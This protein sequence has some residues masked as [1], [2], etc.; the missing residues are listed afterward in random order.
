MALK[1]MSCPCHLQIFNSSLR[2]WRDLPMRLSEFGACHRDEPSGA[3][4]GLLRT[5]G[6]V[7]DD[8]HVL[9]MPQQIESEV[10]RFVGLLSS[11]YSD[12]GF[13]E[14]DVALSL[15]PDKRAGSDEDRDQAEAQLLAAARSTG[16]E[17][18]SAGGRRGILWSEAGICLDRS[19]RQIMAVWHH[20][21]RL[22]AT[23]TAWRRYA[24]SN[25]NRAV[26]V[27]LHHAIFGSMGR[28][29]ESARASSW[30]TALLAGSGPGCRNAS[31]EHQLGIAQ[32]LKRHLVAAGLRPKLFDQSET[33]ARRIVSS[34]DLWFLSWPSLVSGSTGWL[35]HAAITAGTMGCGSAY[36]H[37]QAAETATRRLTES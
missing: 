35:Y 30:T 19:A 32:E 29:S 22:C 10:A 3:M 37:C 17:S 34:H 20:S 33:L 24:D 4:H 15:R 21:A 27:M 28:S 18:R 16:L 23:R 26:P 2:S 7:Q 8:A 12:L 5:R 11:V 9:C 31:L 36:G 1:P 14:F 6:F 13:E 25:G